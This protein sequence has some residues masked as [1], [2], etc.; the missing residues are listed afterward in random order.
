MVDDRLGAVLL[1]D[2]L[3]AKAPTDR[4]RDADRREPD[5]DAREPED[6]ARRSVV[7]A[8]R[9][10]CLLGALERSWTARRFA[11][12]DLERHRRARGHGDL[13]PVDLLAVTHLDLVRSGIDAHPTRKLAAFL[14]VDHHTRAVW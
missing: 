3:G 8:F 14:P 10:P 6:M 7:H 11:E 5:T 2:V 1:V 9:S 4:A 12:M 13:G